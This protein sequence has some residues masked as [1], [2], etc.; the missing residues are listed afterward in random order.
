MRRLNLAVMLAVTVASVAFVAVPRIRAVGATLGTARVAQVMP[1]ATPASSFAPLMTPA[2]QIGPP[3]AV[4][5]VIADS[6][7][8]DTK[9]V[10]AT[11]I[12]RNARTDTTG[13]GPLWQFDLCGH[14]CVH[15]L[16]VQTSTTATIADDAETTVAGTFYR[17]LQRGRFSQDDM[18]ISIPG[19][20]PPDQTFDWRRQLEGYPPSR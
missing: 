6:H 8:Y 15:V 12:V 7:E 9:P 4:D 20:L 16:E 3:M 5:D 1:S 2:P 19:G 14:R 18:L 17:H 13:L 10:Q 11:G